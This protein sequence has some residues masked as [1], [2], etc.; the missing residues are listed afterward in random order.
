MKVRFEW[1]PYRYLPYERLFA[2]RE[3]KA[4]LGRD[5]TPTLNGLA[6]ES[7][8]GWETQAYR[9][10]YFAQALGDNGARITPLQALLEG[11]A[12][13]VTQT[14][15]PGMEIAP[16]LQR[17]RTRYSAHGLH[18]YRGKFN[19]Q[20]VRV[21]GNML[22]L[23]PGSWVLDPFC[24]SG[25]SLLE[26]IHNG[27]NAIGVDLNPLAVMIAR[28]KIA[29]MHV[30]SE[31]LV[32]QTKMLKEHLIEKSGHLRLDRAFDEDE[33]L[34]L[35]GPKWEVYL[36]GLGYL[37]AWFTDSVLIQLSSIM[38]GIRE[39]PSAEVRL[40]ARVILSDVLREVSLQEP[41]DLRIRRRKS[42]LQNEPV[43]PLF[44]QALKFKIGSISSTRRNL[45]EIPAIQAALLGD[46]RRC[47]RVVR[48]EA[49]LDSPQV[50]DAAITSPPYAT[51]LPYIDTQRLS[52][53]LLG[54]VAP[55]EIRAAERSLTGNREISRTERLRIEK[56]IQANAANLTP[57]CWGLCQEL[58]ASVNESVDGFRRRNVPALI[59]K[60]LWDMACMF[61][62]VYELL[63]PGAAFALLVGRNKT[64]LGRQAFVIDTPHLLRVLA[65]AKGF[66]TQECIELETYQ[67]FDVHRANSIRSESLLILR[68]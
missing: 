54:L 20:V 41:A 42:F 60:Y 62:E 65:E 64:R 14:G 17:Q 35:G 33:K 12:N 40:I 24:G 30:S 66:T 55:D 48:S 67:R 51:A 15:L 45:A 11:S 49:P 9:T 37:R 29:A 63:R 23:S 59:Y 53:M 68:R 43:I 18:E 39:L 25:T 28:A 4:L 36:H 22:G 56:D 26:G 2:H 1:H 31:T 7:N 5:P 38:Q 34:R 10:T 13:G 16:V 58:R 46:A 50:F 57:E 27:W 32:G 52:L 6:T 44:L 61:G 19:P 21:I 8:E 3:L 47:R